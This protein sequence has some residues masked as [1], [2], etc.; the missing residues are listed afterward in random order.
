MEETIRQQIFTLLEAGH[1]CSFIQKTLKI[2]KTCYYSNKKRFDNK[3]GTARRPGTGQPRKV[4]TPELIKRV[5]EKIRRNPRRSMRKLAKD[6]NVGVTT[7][8]K[9]VREDIGVK[10]FK[11]QYRQLLSA[12]TRQKRLERSKLL[13]DWHAD[14]DDVI[15]IYS[16]EK[17]CDI[18]QKFN[19][20]NDRILCNKAE[21]IDPD[22]RIAGKA[23]KSASI[24]VWA[25]VAS[26][27]E[28]SPVFRIPDGVKINQ[29]VYLEFLQEK[30]KPWIESTFQN[31]LI[32]FTQD[33]APAHGAKMVQEWCKKNF[34]H[35]WDKSFWPPSSPDV[36]PLDF[37][38]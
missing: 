16:D 24:M 4:R 11:L 34:A 31:Q 27:G 8:H 10:P 13:L 26:N 9:L 17:L 29:H 38:M 35:F 15:M 30:V 6:H 7:M 28:K 25:A 14:H 23:Q 1:G 33:S 36:N 2:S 3:E 21:S 12:P 22:E 20:Q 37:A 32:C 5:R 18:S 19:K